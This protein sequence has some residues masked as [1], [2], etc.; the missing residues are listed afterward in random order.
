[1]APADAIPPI[2]APSGGDGVRAYVFTCNKSCGGHDLDG[3]HLDEL[4][5]LGLFVGY[6]EKIS[7]KGL[8]QLEKIKGRGD[9]MAMS[10]IMAESLMEFGM[11]RSM[12]SETW[13]KF[14]DPQASRI[15]SEPHKKCKNRRFA[16]PCLP[17][18]Q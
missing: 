10:M 8:E 2:Q 16:R 6:V 14:M 7:D 9:D 15:Q 1:V 11:V 17:G 5:D 3:K 12:D 13:Y 18:M 4:K